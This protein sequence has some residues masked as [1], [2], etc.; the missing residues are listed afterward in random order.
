MAPLNLSSEWY[1]QMDES[2]KL[3]KNIERKI[4]GKIKQGKEY[5]NIKDGA[6]TTNEQLIFNKSNAK[7]VD[8]FSINYSIFMTFFS[9]LSTY[10]ALNGLVAIDLETQAYNPIDVDANA[11][12]D[13]KTRYDEIYRAEIPELITLID[14]T[15]DNLIDSNYISPPALTNITGNGKQQHYL[16]GKQETAKRQAA[17]KNM[18]SYDSQMHLIVWF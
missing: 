2:I 5:K 17:V 14:N 8:I 11:F 15:Y 6:N 3:K 12:K 9:G 1:E 18:F 13:M 16:L 7:N 4:S 10:C